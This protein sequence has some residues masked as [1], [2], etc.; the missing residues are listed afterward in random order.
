MRRGTKAIILSFFNFRKGAGAKATAGAFVSCLVFIL[1][2]LCVLA[3][4][5]L[6]YF[7]YYLWSDEVF[8]IIIV[9]AP[10]S[11][12]DYTEENPWYSDFI[13]KEND[14]AYD[15]VTYYNWMEKKDAFLTVVFPE[16]FDEKI[17][18]RFS[19]DDHDPIEVLTYYE[20]NSLD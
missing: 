12:V 19:D 9:N 8:D 4:F 16:D 1:V 2:L 10:D 11:F 5:A 17:E 7:P 14:A 13:F 20:T 18:E 15:F 3:S 6:W